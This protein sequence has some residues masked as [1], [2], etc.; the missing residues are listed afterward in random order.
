MKLTVLRVVRDGDC[1]DGKTCPSLSRTD[2]HSYV[3]VG[4]AV[5]DL[6]ALSAA[7]LGIG[8]GEVAIEVPASLLEG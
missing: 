3:L 6:E 2:R 8:P 4:K 7:R 5:T 1:Y